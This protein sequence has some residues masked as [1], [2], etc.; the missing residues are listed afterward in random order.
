MSDRSDYEELAD[1]CWREAKE[2][3]APEQRAFLLM[4][5]QAWQ[6]LAD[7]SRELR[8]LFGKDGS[9]NTS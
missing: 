8:V 2:R 3:E 1:Q 6:R 5:A 9:D 7:R 4:M